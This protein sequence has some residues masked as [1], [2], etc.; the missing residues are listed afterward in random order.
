MN[1]TAEIDKAGRI[2][3]PKKLRDALHLIPGTRLKMHQEGE[4]LIVQTE[5]QPGRLYEKDGTLVYDAGGSPPGDVLDWIRRDREDRDRA[6]LGMLK[7][8]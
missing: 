5:S 8:R 6:I 3:V 1:A 2:V 4:T 7:K